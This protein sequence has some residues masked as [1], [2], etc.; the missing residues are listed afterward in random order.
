MVLCGVYCNGLC[1]GVCFHVCASWIGDFSGW[2]QGGGCISGVLG[3][4]MCVLY[5]GECEL[6][7]AG[8]LWG[9]GI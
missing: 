3:G 1:D 8:G 4:G 7:V 9:E 6:G 5:S 2:V